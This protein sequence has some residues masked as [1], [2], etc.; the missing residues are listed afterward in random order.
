MKR[1]EAAGTTSNGGVAATP[2]TVTKRAK[3][4]ASKKGPATAEVEGEG[5]ED[6]SEEGEPPKKKA[7]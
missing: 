3:P 4:A 7:E 5:G 1:F 6:E 2:K